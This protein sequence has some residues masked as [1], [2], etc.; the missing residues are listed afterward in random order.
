M[1][2]F[3]TI[4]GQ[5]GVPVAILFAV[6]FAFFKFIPSVC[7]A[8]RKVYDDFTDRQIDRDKFLEEKVLNITQYISDNMALISKNMDNIDNRVLRIDDK[9]DAVNVKVDKLQ[10]DINS[11]IQK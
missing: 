10:Q 5:L 2:A 7:D 9:V 6:G 11:L 1:E 4:A 3:L 8:L